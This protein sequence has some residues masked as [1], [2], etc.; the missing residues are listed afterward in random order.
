MFFSGAM[1]DFYKRNDLNLS[2]GMYYLKTF[3]PLVSTLVLEDILQKE[4]SGKKVIKLWGDQLT[5]T[6]LEEE[7]LNFSLFGNEENYLIFK[8][9]S[10]KPDCLRFFE[11]NSLADKMII[12][13]SEKEAELKKKLKKRIELLTIIEPKF[14]EGR[15]T[16][17]GICRLLQVKL[18]ADVFDYVF[19]NVETDFSSLYQVVNSLRGINE[20]ITITVVKEFINN[21]RVDNFELASLLSR[22]DYYRF[23]DYL[24]AKNFS[25]EQ[26]VQLFRFLQS[27]F[28]KMSN[29]DYSS[30]KARLSKYDKD[31]IQAATKWKP[32][33]LDQVLKRLDDWE[34]RSKSKDQSLKEDFMLNLLRLS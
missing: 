16:L 17:E 22:K 12:F 13:V 19:K 15:E 21:E 33:E 26:L 18:N 20:K 30:Q 25:F 9:E 3:C 14:W 5:L 1:W 23:F 11:E 2:M 29:P 4:L 28:L 10:L 27:H 6:K 7:F 24:L 32:R 34:V 8:P 31:L